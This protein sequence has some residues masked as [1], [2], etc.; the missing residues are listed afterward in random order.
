M[1]YLSYPS[2]SKSRLISLAG[3]SV[4]T[5][6]ICPGYGFEDEVLA[7]LG[8]SDYYSYLLGQGAD[9]EENPDDVVYGWVGK[10]KG[11]IQEIL[12]Q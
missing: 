3:V 5:I 11:K 10:N 2:A 12:K 6:T 1:E 7:D 9:D 4:P 8:Y